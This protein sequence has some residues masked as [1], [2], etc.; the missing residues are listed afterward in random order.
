MK[1]RRILTAAFMA[2]VLLLQTTAM[3]RADASLT[4]NLSS[5]EDPVKSRDTISALVE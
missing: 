4:V 2:T 5:S 3:L 1:L